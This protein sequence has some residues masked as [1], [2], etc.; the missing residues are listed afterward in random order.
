MLFTGTHVD[1][2][3]PWRKVQFTRPAR[4]LWHD[5]MKRCIAGYVNELRQRNLICADLDGIDRNGDVHAVDQLMKKI[6]NREASAM[7]WRMVPG[8][9]KYFADKKGNQTSCTMLL[10]RIAMANLPMMCAAAVTRM[11]WNTSPSASKRAYRRWHSRVCVRGPRGSDRGQNGKCSTDSLVACIFPGEWAGK[12]VDMVKAATVG[13]FHE[14]DLIKIGARNT[15]LPACSTSTPSSLLT[16]RAMDKLVPHRWFNDP[17]PN[18]PLP[19]KVAYDGNADKLFNEDL[20]PTGSCVADR[21]QGIP[22][23]RP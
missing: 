4:Q 16:Q 23:S 5:Y 3:N 10:L 12:T 8:K 19:G 18:G 7:F 2:Q 22:T 17:T 11:P 21:R 6:V 15:R 13:R 9:A 20:Q 14:D 1:Q